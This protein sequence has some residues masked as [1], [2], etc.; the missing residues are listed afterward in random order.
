MILTILNEIL[1]Y[2]TPRI[3]QSFRLL[4]PFGAAK[5]QGKTPSCNAASVK[6]ILLIVIFLVDMTI[7]MLI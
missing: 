2:W 5:Q 6:K 1:I 3:A 7:V 4:S